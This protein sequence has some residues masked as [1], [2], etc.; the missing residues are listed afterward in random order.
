MLD[1]YDKQLEIL[2]PE[3]LAELAAIP[4]VNDEENWAGRG[5]RMR[6]LAKSRGDHEPEEK[7]T[8]VQLPIWAEP[9][10]VAPNAM[11]RSALF[12]CARLRKFV[13]D[14]LIV[15]WPDTQ[16]S[17]SGET[18]NQFDETVW[19]QLVHTFRLQG[20][21]PNFKVRFNAKP[22]SRSIGNGKRVQGGKDIAL[23]RSALIRLRGG[24]LLLSHK[25]LEYGGGLLQDF[26]L[27]EDRGHFVATL[28]PKYLQILGAGHTRLD[29]ETRKAL[30]TGIATWMHRYILSHRATAKQP[31]R[32]GLDK[33]RTLSGMSSSPKEFRRHL[34]R[35][36]ARLESH[37]VI[38]SWGITPNKALEFVRPKRAT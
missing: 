36:L 27:D 30:P 24:T 9:D 37:G 8:P 29:W 21:P 20:E 5:E 11:L 4:E 15:S 18:L 10:R 7:A 13:K 38:A 23:L 2:M 12:S 35:T 34:K 14:E 3:K 22:F 32:I 26:T 25:G 6:A 28:N 33:L 16:I 17:F 19:M 1:D 31:H